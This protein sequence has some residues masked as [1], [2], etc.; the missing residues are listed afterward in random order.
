VT[1]T[2][3]LVA[4]ALLGG[5]GVAHADLPPD[6]DV[7]EA[8]DE[9]NLVS[10]APRHGVTGTLAVG[11]SLTLG[12]GVS[13]AVGKGGALSARLGA[14]AT[15]TTVITFEIVGGGFAHE[16]GN[17]GVELSNAIVLAAGMQH[18]ASPTSALFF[19][20]AGGLGTFTRDMPAHVSGLAGVAGV[21][22][23]VARL[24]FVT[25]DVEFFL[26]SMLVS[27]GMVTTGALCFGGT[28]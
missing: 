21:G 26:T 8:A 20:L 10:I 15:P 19:R 5:I 28:I 25:L 12:L 23:D 16:L 24:R 17:S 9:A 6:P 13:N 11:G 2:R 22:A 7:V 14:V 18:Y 27:G 3:L 4:V 1:P